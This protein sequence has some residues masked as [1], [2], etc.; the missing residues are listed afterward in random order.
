MKNY[1]EELE[2]PE[3]E[4]GM[5]GARGAP[6]AEPATSSV[7]DVQK[8]VEPKPRGGNR[9]AS[10]KAGDH[11]GRKACPA[12]AVA[13]AAAE[14]AEETLEATVKQERQATLRF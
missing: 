10:P 9:Q 13:A 6:R 14:A 3:R 4:L 2:E 5:A 12:L 7:F 8:W 11:R 1:A